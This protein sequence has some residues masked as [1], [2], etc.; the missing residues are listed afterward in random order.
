MWYKFNSD[1]IWDKAWE[2]SMRL[3]MFAFEKRKCDFSENDEWVCKHRTEPT[4]SSQTVPY[5]GIQYSYTHRHQVSVSTKHTVQL[6]YML[7]K[8]SIKLPLINSYTRRFYFRLTCVCVCVLCMQTH[9]ITLNE[10]AYEDNDTNIGGW[11]YSLQ[12][13]SFLWTFSW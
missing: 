8:Q 1:P 5:N 2:S 3:K 4:I 13:L 6:Q 7:K 12:V 9:T 11:K 10:I